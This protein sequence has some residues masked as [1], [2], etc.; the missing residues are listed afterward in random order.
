MRLK[1]EIGPKFKLPSLGK[2][3]EEKE[4]KM[5]IS[6][7]G[8]NLWRVGRPIRNAL[9]FSVSFLFERVMLV[10]NDLVV[11]LTGRNYFFPNKPQSFHDECAVYCRC[12]V[13]VRA[14][15]WALAGW[16]SLLFLYLSETLWSIPPHPACAMF[17]TNHGS[18]TD[19]LTGKCVPSSSTYAGKWYSFFTL[20]TNYHCEHHDF[21]T[22]PLHKL[23]KL[24]NIAPDF[25]PKGSKDN[26]FRIMKKAFSDPDFYACMDV[27]VNLG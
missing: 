2:G 9:A 3:G 1:G 5:S 21:P 23:G 10:V 22:I 20:G 16:K 24:R 18:G 14:A 8:F 11:A 4:V 13:A 7:S 27:G 12:A 15:L 6:K 25:Y 26:V 19:Q 17:V